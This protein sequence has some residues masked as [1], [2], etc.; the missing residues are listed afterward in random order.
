METKLIAADIA[1]AAGVTTIVAS[2]QHPKV[3][4]DIIEWTVQQSQKEPEPP[5]TGARTAV[6]LLHR[7]PHTSFSPSEM[8][9]RSLKSWTFHTLN[10]S[11]SVII[12]HGAHTVLSRRDSGGRLLPAGVIKVDGS[13]AA[14]QAVRILVRRE[15]VEEETETDQRHS[16]PHL[17]RLSSAFNSIPPTPTLSRR[18]S[19]EFRDSSE[20][21]EQDHLSVDSPGAEDRIP[22]EEL[23]EVGR[24]LANYN[25]AEIS[26]VKGQKRFVFLSHVNRLSLIDRTK[27]QRS[28]YH[29]TWLCRFGVCG[30]KHYDTRSSVGSPA[31]DYLL[32][33]P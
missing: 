17:K 25:S 8:P 12:D 20:H 28:N 9:L 23:M 15:K 19:T 4:L 10:P 29:I 24:G 3:V 11:G 6:T 13:F 16:T 1:T 2:S 14:G 33:L 21:N 26:K 5:A 32:V 30:G 22:E 7:P 31:T 27:Q 18:A